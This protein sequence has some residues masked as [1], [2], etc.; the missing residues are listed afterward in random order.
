[1]SEALGNCKSLQNIY[2]NFNSCNEITDLGL[3]RISKSIEKLADLEVL[4]LCFSHCEKITEKG[5][6]SIIEGLKGLRS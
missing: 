6:Q 2:L 5:V 3:Q 1:M 4:H